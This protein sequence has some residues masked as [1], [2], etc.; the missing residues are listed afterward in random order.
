[1]FQISIHIAIS[2]SL[3]RLCFL[4]KAGRKTASTQKP[5]KKT[6]SIQTRNNIQIAGNWLDPYYGS[7][8]GINTDLKRQ[9]LQKGNLVEG[10][11]RLIKGQRKNKLSNPKSSTTST[12]RVSHG[13]KLGHMQPYTVI[14]SL[15]SP[16]GPEVLLLNVLSLLCQKQSTTSHSAVPQH[17]S[18]RARVGSDC[19]FNI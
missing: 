13:L 2:T 18:H 4:S 17:L 3:N 6:I 7:Q 19:T 15:S 1:M 12:T 5:F 16:I 11:I 8:L 14:R 10:V 9:V